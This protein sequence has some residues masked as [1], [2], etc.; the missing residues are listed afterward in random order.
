MG[1]EGHEAA[2]FSQV[3]LAEGQSNSWQKL[4]QYSFQYSS[5]KQHSQHA[6]SLGHSGLKSPSTIRSI[7]KLK[8]RPV[9]M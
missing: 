4:K 5:L 9:G 6:S 7:K 8:H 1:H 3:S 2:C